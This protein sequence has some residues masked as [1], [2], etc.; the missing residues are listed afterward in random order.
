MPPTLRPATIRSF[1]HSISA[2]KSG[3]TSSMAR[4]AAMPARSGTVGCPD[5][6]AASTTVIQSPEPGGDSHLRPSLPRP[7][8]CSSAMTTEKEAAPA[9]AMLRARS[10]VEPRR[11]CTSRSG[12]PHRSAH[13]AT[14]SPS[15]VRRGA[16]R[17][18]GTRGRAAPESRDTGRSGGTSGRAARSGRSGSQAGPS[19]RP[20]PP[21]NT[22]GAVPTADAASPASVS[23]RRVAP[24][25]AGTDI[26]NENSAASSD[27]TPSQSA[28]TTVEPE[29]EMPGTSANAWATPM[30][31]ATPSPRAPENG[32]GAS[33]GG[34]SRSSCSSGGEPR[35]SPP[36]GPPSSRSCIPAPAA[37]GS[38]RLTAARALHSSPPVTRNAT[39][40]TAG[41]SN[42]ASTASPR[43]NQAAAAGTLASA[44]SPR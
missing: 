17:S 23:W 34:S 12:T 31:I 29:R 13:C 8:V 37:G 39:P 42:D 20:P 9:R 25:M 21:P 1:G 22:S 16:T 6:R 5:G 10:L 44:M 30:S 18:T 35:G 41:V 2:R 32:P 14:G 40:A 36:I 19:R 7:R 38:P 4:A 28:V 27:S 26:R 15:Q 43:T 33:G 24:S 3:Q 11:A